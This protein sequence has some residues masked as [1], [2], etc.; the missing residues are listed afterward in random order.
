MSSLTKFTTL[1]DPNSRTDVGHSSEG[2]REAQVEDPR[3][4]R[5]QHP[6]PREELRIGRNTAFQTQSGFGGGWCDLEGESEVV[7]PMTERGERPFGMTFPV[8]RMLPR[9]IQNPRQLQRPPWI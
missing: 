8:C 9:T 4:E 7:A 5:L 1:S 3:R 2:D 6:R